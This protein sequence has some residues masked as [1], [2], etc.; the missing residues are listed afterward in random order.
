MKRYEIVICGNEEIIAEGVLPSDASP[1]YFE[2][3]AAAFVAAA[4]SEIERHPRYIDHLSWHDD[5]NYARWRGGTHY[6]VGETID[7]QKYGY[8]S[9]LIVTHARNPPKWLCD[10]CDAA[11]VAAYAEAAKAADAA[12]QKDLTH[13]DVCEAAGDLETAERIRDKWE[14]F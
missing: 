7:G 3:V 14:G 1:I 2:T 6:R 9:G 10:L 13:A 12:K 11:S 8:G 4:A 5:S